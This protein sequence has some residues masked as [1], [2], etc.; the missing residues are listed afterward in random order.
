MS[1]DEVNRTDSGAHDAGARPTSGRQ[2]HP[3]DTTNGA[4]RGHLSR[5][6][7]D[8]RFPAEGDGPV[9]DDRDVTR[10][11]EA[12]PSLQVAAYTHSGPLPDVREYAGYEQVLPGAA[13]RIL[14]MAEES[15]TAVAHAMHADARATEAAAESVREDGRAIRR[16]QYIFGGLS[17]LLIVAVIVMSVLG[18]GWA[19][20]VVALCGMVTAYG[21]IVRPI[22]PHR[23]RPKT[24]EGDAS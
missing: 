2:D 6:E 17:M 3:Q 4:G 24:A 10:F 1:D 21:V 19:A 14:R 15:N 23:W 12:H 9:P 22:N 13:E 18:S 7:D 8:G 11:L 16:G 5:V 20:A